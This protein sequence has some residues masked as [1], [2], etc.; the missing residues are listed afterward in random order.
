MSG[1]MTGMYQVITSFLLLVC[2]MSKCCSYSCHFH[3]N[4][5][6]LWR[7]KPFIQRLYGVCCQQDKK[8]F[9]LALPLSNGLKL[10]AHSL[11]CSNRDNFG[12]NESLIRQTTA[13]RSIT[14]EKDYSCCHQ[15]IWC[16][17]SKLSYSQQA[18]CVGYNF[19]QPIWPFF[20]IFH[21]LSNF[22]RL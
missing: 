4:T 6:L 2:S 13:P 11:P 21:F 17:K 8:A 18:S 1:D 15:C 5:F 10:A 16:T 7:K 9:M 3:A 19:G 12:Q 14:K 22:Q 20:S